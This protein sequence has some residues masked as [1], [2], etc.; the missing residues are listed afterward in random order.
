MLIFF[1]ICFFFIRHRNRR[2]LAREI[3]TETARKFDLSEIKEA[4][5]NFEK[6]IGG[7]GFGKVYYGRLQDGNESEIAIKVQNID[8]SQ[9]IQEFLNEVTLLSRIHHRNLVKF[10]GYCRQEDNN[11]LV[12]EFMHNG[13]LTYRLRGP[14]EERIVS[15]IKRLEIAED[16]AKGIEYLHKG[17]LPAIMHRDLKTSNI[18]LDKDMKAK[19][20]DFGLSKF[21]EEFSYVSSTV[22]GTLGYLDPEYYTTQ[23]YTD[24]SDVYSFGIILLELISGHPPASE[25]RFGPNFSHIIA[26]SNEHIESGNIDAIIDPSLEKSYDIQSIW[27]IAEIAIMC[28]RPMGIERPNI[29]EVLKEIQEAILLEQK[30]LVD[31]ADT[32]DVILGKPRGST[33]RFDARGLKFPGSSAS[34]TDE[35]EHPTLR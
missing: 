17:C 6:V 28:V 4:T 1:T 8:S 9:G 21:V 32:F 33:A 19:V 24:K 25:T 16:A 15:W 29:S 26:W 3:D 31:R 34:F 18:L 13:T 20:S 35:I 23:Q 5:A 12:Y 30:I 27:K 11:M 7:G 22:K 10:I 2:L 14:P